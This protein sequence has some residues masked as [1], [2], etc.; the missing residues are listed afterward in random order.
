MKFF[1]V[2]LKSDK[3]PQTN[4][5]Q[6]TLDKV[7]SLIFITIGALALVMMVIAG[8]RY[9][10]AE[11]EPAKV[12]EAKNMIIYSFIGLLIAASAAAIVNFVIG[13]A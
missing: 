4:A 8:L 11:G 6:P 13:R 9:I 3:L 12:A 2:L 5:D 10:F 7:L 1:I